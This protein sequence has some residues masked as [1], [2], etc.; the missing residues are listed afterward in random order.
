MDEIIGTAPTRVDLAGGTLDLWPVHHLLDYK[1][2]V[3]VAVNLPAEVRI[4]LSRS[5]HYEFL[6]EDLS[7]EF[8]GNFHAAVA[9]DRLP[10]F[11]LLLS[12]F[13]RPD[14]P[15]LRIYSQARSPAGAGL[16]GSSCLAVTLGASLW[17][18]RQCFE[19]LP[20]MSE[21]KL[22]QTAQDVE[23]CL[24]AA[25]TGCQDYWAAVRGGINVIKFPYGGVSVST[26]SEAVTSQSLND[27]LLICYSGKSR[28]SAINNWE[29]YKRVF[30]KDRAILEDFNKI[31]RLAEQCAEAISSGDVDQAIQYSKREWELRCHL[32]PAIETPETKAIDRA[33][34]AHGAEFTRVCGAG[35]GGVM[36]IFVGDIDRQNVFQAV[37]KAGGTVLSAG[38]ANQG[39]KV[40]V[41]AL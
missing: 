24:I 37:T 39:L 30:D 5:K 16:G 32:W 17:R 34:K 21:E 8:T 13:W 38:V 15:P 11:G 27:K 20:E 28:A 1:A 18:A 41:G 26:I 33:A 19:A 6:S 23:A 2:T 4:T 31:G 22:V 7:A 29:I 10:L 35:G 9:N 3:N 25:P 40:S 36:G 12:A 14:L